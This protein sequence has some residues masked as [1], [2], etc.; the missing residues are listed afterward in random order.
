MAKEEETGL[1]VA[2]GRNDDGKT[3]PVII[4]SINGEDLAVL[5]DSES[6]KQLALDILE[7]EAQCGGRQITAVQRSDGQ[8]FSS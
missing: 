6:A 7:V 2:I 3:V 5:M 8:K 4:I 1:A